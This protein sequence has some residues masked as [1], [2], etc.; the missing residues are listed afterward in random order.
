[1]K[2]KSSDLYENLEALP[3]K[4]KITYDDVT[5]PAKKYVQNN[6]YW[7]EYDS[8]TQYTRLQVF[9]IL[10]KNSNTGST[11]DYSCTIDTIHKT[12]NISG[13]QIIQ[14]ML[15]FLKDIGVKE[16]YLIDDTN[17]YCQGQR[18]DLALYLILKKGITFYQRFGFKFCMSK[19]SY[20]SDIF[21]DETQML[22]IL[23]KNVKDFNNIK[24][25]IMR[26]GL[27]KMF[28]L[29]TKIVVDNGYSKTEISIVYIN[30]GSIM[31]VHPLDI[32]MRIQSYIPELINML[33]IIKPE[34][35]ITTVKDLLMYYYD[36]KDCQT[37]STIIDYFLTFQLYKVTYGNIVLVNKYIKIL[38]MIDFIKGSTLRLTF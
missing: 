15:S 4:F 13:T 17:V 35:N 8:P 34:S 23:E 3:D 28:N 38:R 31:D 21:K 37:Y 6:I 20:L 16:V 33:N 24:L 29:L 12:K 5:L 11:D 2:F 26:S 7:I 30:D 32:S 27:V 1:M 36:E 19:T 14:T 25:S 10:F 22:Q 18:I 9:K